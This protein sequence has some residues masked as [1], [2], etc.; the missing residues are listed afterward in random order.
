MLVD[1]L[2]AP[3]YSAHMKHLLLYCDNFDTFRSLSPKCDYVTFG[4]L[5]SQTACVVCNVHAPVL[6]DAVS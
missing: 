6:S 4:C 1:D 3:S 5:L 2:C